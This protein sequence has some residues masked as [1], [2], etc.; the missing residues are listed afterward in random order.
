MSG[1]FELTAHPFTETSL[2]RS[3]AAVGIG[4]L[5]IGALIFSVG[6]WLG[7]RAVQ[8]FRAEGGQPSFY[9][10]EFGPAVMLA[11]GHGLQNPDARSAGALEAFLSERTDAIGCT[12]LP[13]AIPVTT[14]DAFQRA[15]RYLEIAVASV[16]RVTGVSWSRL[17][18]LPGV[19][20]GTV[21]A[22]TYGLFRLAL[23]RPL[24]LAGMVP[25][26]MSTPNLMLVPHIRDYAKGPFL[27]AI[28]LMMGALVARPTDGRRTIAVS[29]LAGSVVG[30]GLGF[31]TDLMIALPPFLLTLAFLVPAI[32]ATMR[33]VAMAV[34]LASFAIVASPM[35]R[36]YAS[37]NN[38]GPVVLLGL[39]APFDRPLGIEPS[40]YELG[41]QYSD[42]LVFSIV[43]SYAIRVEHKPQGVQYATAEHGRT[44]MAYVGQV[45]RVFPADFVTRVTAAVRAVPTYFLASSLYPPT[46][47]RSPVLLQLYRIRASIS[48]RLAV[49]GGIALATATIVIGM[50]SPRAAW[51]V[52][53]VMIA[54]AGGSAIQFHERHFYYLQLLPWWAFGVLAQVATR[55]RTLLRSVAMRHLLSGSVLCV[56]VIISV[57][58]AIVA[59]RAYQRR[60][61]ARLFESYETAPRIRLS[62]LH[63]DIGPGRTLITTPDWFERRLPVASWIQTQF[64]AV[65]FRDDLCGP[66]DLPLTARYQAALPELD[67]SEPITVR[68]VKDPVAASTLFLPTYDRPDDSSR[69]R[70]LEVAADQ[71][72]CIADISRV[73][74]IDR[75]PLLLTTTLAAG[76]RLGPLYQRLH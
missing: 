47:V 9:Q 74:G 57:G 60:T 20:F 22:L 66:G 38:I 52:V 44:A 46:W 58:G 68:L 72:R 76:W 71:A 36:D 29:A 23:S 18:I 42:S 56:V 34:F 59:S 41:G 11:C 49:A 1:S 17:V 43:N 19:L 10:S 62:T 28:M 16:W 6:V 64:L 48:S 7:I 21:A 4:D 63:R 53:L 37:G 31:R 12:E 3:K 33:V 15:S 25:T 75:T 5:A 55:R 54:F 69:F 65:T 45:G 61:A 2:T 51:L 14:L 13:A 8:A 35:L 67:F 27:L 40:V 70:G 39:S 32:S 24:A 73:E 26:F 30:L 50:A